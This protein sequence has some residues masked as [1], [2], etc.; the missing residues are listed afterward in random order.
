MKNLNGNSG[1][2]I[3]FDAHHC[4]L[5]AAVKDRMQADLVGLARQV[6]DFPVAEIQIL[7]EH[8]ARSNEYTVKTSLILPGTTLMGNDHDPALHAA[9]LRCL[10]SLEE[11]V[12]GYKERLDRQPERQKQEKGT[13]QDL[14][15]SIDPDAA[16]LAEAVRAGDYAA[17]RTAA[18]G[19]EDGVRQRAGRWI[20]RYPEV[21]A[22]IG[23]GLDLDDI[24][25]AV[26]LDAFEG[27]EHRPSQVRFGDWL[28]GLIDPAVRALR[29]PDGDA[30][31]NVRLVRSARETQPGAAR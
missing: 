31:E 12:R 25:E 14:R 30:L 29:S 27:F 4:E 17:F 2:Q 21:A 6:A 7:V 11:N 13:H 19:Y 3:R 10:Q 8:N 5:S 24:V 1:L 23:H 15:P 26:F 16:A 9:F 22:R 18:F 20:E 28:D